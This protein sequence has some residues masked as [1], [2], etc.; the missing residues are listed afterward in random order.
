MAHAHIT[1]PKPNSVPP[2]RGFFPLMSFTI[3]AGKPALITG[4]QSI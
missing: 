4:L 1:R 2:E 3:S